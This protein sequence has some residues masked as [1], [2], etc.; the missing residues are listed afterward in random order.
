M[1]TSV[2]RLDDVPVSERF[3][4][5]WQAVARSVVSVSAS[6]DR[7]ADFWAEMTTIDLGSVPISRIKCVGFEAHRSMSRIRSSD[8]E[9][10]L[11]SL[12]LRGIAGIQQEDRETLLA[13]TDLMLCDTSLPYKAWTASDPRD[14]A[15]ARHQAGSDGIILRIPH[16]A[17][18]F[19]VPEIRR[20]LAAGI[21]GR[22]GVAALL[23]D[24]L[25]G[26]VTRSDELSVADVGRLS[27]VTLDLVIAVLAHELE[28]APTPLLTDPSRTLTLRIRAFIEQRLGQVDLSPAVIAAAHHISLRHLYRM[29]QQEGH[30]VGGWIRQRRLERCRRA[31]ADPRL[32]GIPINAIAARWGFPNDSHF[33]RTFRRAFGVTPAGY[34]WQARKGRLIGDN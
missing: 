11:I 17:L 31:L 15:T 33:N 13:P 34:R 4:F 7:E 32:D 10:Y 6:S 2:L 16:D 18:P 29:F 8:P 25:R 30:T 28:V 12:V 23:S 21:T 26:I 3:D 22:Q 5:W 1:I 14:T 20:L 9:A 19:P 27:T 24:L